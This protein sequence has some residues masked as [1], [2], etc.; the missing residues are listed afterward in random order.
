MTPDPKELAFD[1][2]NQV[3]LGPN[4]LILLVVNSFEALTDSCILDFVGAYIAMDNL[5]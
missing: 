3:Y 1:Y 2:Q 4:C 5:T